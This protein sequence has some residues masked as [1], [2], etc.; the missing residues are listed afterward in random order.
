MAEV[1]AV[2]ICDRPRHGRMDVCRGHHQRLRLWGEMRTEVPF[3]AVAPK[4]RDRPDCAADGCARKA[5]SFKLEHRSLCSMHLRRWQR[6]GKLEY[7]DRSAVW[8]KIEGHWS[9]L[10]EDVS[11]LGMHGRLR[12]YRGA[13]S[14]HTCPCGQP[15]YEWALDNGSPR[16]VSDD[17]G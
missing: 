6:N 3:G 14:T 1:C 2:D 5:Y 11:Y 9:W 15:A 7:Q 4:K 16:I 12:R 13:A 8:V 10:G 17:L